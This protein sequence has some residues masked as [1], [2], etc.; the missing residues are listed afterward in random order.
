MRIK[1]RKN[2]L[3]LC[4]LMALLACEE[5]PNEKEKG[6]NYKGNEVTNIDGNGNT[7]G[8]KGVNTQSSDPQNTSSSKN[9]NSGQDG[10]KGEQGQQ[11]VKGN[12]L[13]QKVQ[14]PTLLKQ[15]KIDQSGKNLKDKTPEETKLDDKN[16]EVKN[17]KNSKT[18]KVQDPILLLEQEKIEQLVKKLKLNTP[19][20]TVLD[21]KNFSISFEVKGTES[22][23]VNFLCFENL[24]H[25]APMLGTNCDGYVDAGNIY[26]YNGEGIARAFWK[27]FG[28]DN[29]KNYLLKDR[30]TDIG[31]GVCRSCKISGDKKHLK[32]KDVYYAV[33]N[34]NGDRSKIITLY[35]GNK[36]FNLC[37]K[38]FTNKEDE[39]VQKALTNKAFSEQI[40][41]LTECLDLVL[42]S[43]KYKNSTNANP[44]LLALCPIS[45]SIWGF[46][47]E[48]AAEILLSII[49]YYQKNKGLK[50]IDLCMMCFEPKESEP[51]KTVVKRLS[52]NGKIKLEK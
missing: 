40:T 31:Y 12:T 28:N 23:N 10:K 17:K 24:D 37:Q 38:F 36:L 27:A 34:M 22:S 15:D 50:N 41:W 4:S 8:G 11:N 16:F 44:Y 1:I 52:E 39:D 29:L 26:C 33:G 30:E 3:C 18:Q 9:Q 45:T 49:Y 7:T 14:A 32:E 2:C 48:A 13:T 35:K 51:Y 5:Y 47:Q 43:E 21:Y 42:N 20:E 46:P 6:N 25:G 19:K